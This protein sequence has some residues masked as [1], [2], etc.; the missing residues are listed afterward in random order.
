VTASKKH[1][2]N[3]PFS[4]EQTCVTYL[5]RKRWPWGFKCPFCGSVQ[6]DIAPAYVVVCQYCRKQTSITAHTIMHGSKKNLVAWMRVAWQFCFQNEGLSARGLQRLMGLSCYQTAWRWLQKI[7]RGAAL[8]ESAPCR[9]IVIF[10]IASLPL[11]VSSKGNVTH[12][13]MALELSHDKNARVR[14][15]SL[16]S[17]LPEAITTSINNLIE[18]D[19]ILLVSDPKWL[20]RGCLISHNLPGQPTGEQHKRSQLLFQETLSWLNSVYRGAIDPSNLQDYLD[21]FCFRF[22]TAS[23]PDR[24]DVLDHLLTGLVSTGR[25]TTYIDRGNNAGVRS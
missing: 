16:D 12:I 10:D 20:F 1:I 9:G 8:A 19:T 11:S 3:T 2:S 25:K 4:S 22:N 15:A 14:F 21:E 23:W 17:L 7:R 13:G 5:F 24:L 6:P 18:E